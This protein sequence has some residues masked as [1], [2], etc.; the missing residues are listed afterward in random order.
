[1]TYIAASLF[2]G[3]G[4]QSAFSRVALAMRL[5]IY[6]LYEIDPRAKPA[7]YLRRVIA[8]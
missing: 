2:S 3:I 8:S 4:D 5:V 7:S 6:F 1:M